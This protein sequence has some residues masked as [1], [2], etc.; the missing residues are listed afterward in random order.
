MYTPTNI[1]TTAKPSI[2]VAEW[3]KFTKWYNEY[4]QPTGMRM[5]QAFYN[6]FSLS[7]MRDQDYLGSL[8]E[9]DGNEALTTIFRLFT[10]S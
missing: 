4:A 5:G 7:K 1:T 3:V 9:L 2:E 6:H 8:Y 10:I